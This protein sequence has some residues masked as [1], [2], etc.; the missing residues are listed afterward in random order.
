M[1]RKKEAQTIYEKKLE[2][3]AQCQIW[4]DASRNKNKRT[5]RPEGRSPRRIG[6]RVCILVLVRLQPHPHD[7]FFGFLGK[8][9]FAL[10]NAKV[11][12]NF[13]AVK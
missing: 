1:W 9:V 4:S 13:G 8:N 12:L 10:P 5:G 3:R 11:M 7:F 6:Q 2:L